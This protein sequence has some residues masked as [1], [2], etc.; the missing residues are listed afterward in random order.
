MKSVID[1]SRATMKWT[2]FLCIGFSVLATQGLSPREV[3]AEEPASKKE[4]QNA[5]TLLKQFASLQS[6]AAFFVEKKHL[7]VLAMPIETSG[8][9]QYTAP[10]VL[11]RTTKR[12]STK[13]TIDSNSL[14][15]KDARTQK[16]LALDEK[17]PARAF[18]QVFLNFLR[19]DRLAIEKSFEVKFT[20]D[21]STW[22]LQLLPRKEK[23]IGAI[24]TIKLRGSGLLVSWMEVI[25]Q[26][27]DRTETLFSRVKL[28]YS[29]SRSP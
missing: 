1:L 8:S 5:K 12:P 28:E 10:D 6:F 13:L 19:G 26:H 20:R 16:D 3:Q 4:V 21:D 17:H 15:Y 27:G 23:S 18:V 7:K 24:K 14:H 9:V 29:G 22:E 11:V 2:L 25:D